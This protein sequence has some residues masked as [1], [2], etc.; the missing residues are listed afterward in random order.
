MVFFHILYSEPT[1]KL[2]IVNRVWFVKLYSWNGTQIEQD[3]VQ[4]LGIWL[5]SNLKTLTIKD[6]PSTSIIV[7]LAVGLSL[8]CM[9]SNALYCYQPL[10]CIDSEN[11]N[12]SWLTS[13]LMYFKSRIFFPFQVLSSTL[14][15]VTIVQLT[16]LCYKDELIWSDY[17]ETTLHCE[18]GGRFGV[19]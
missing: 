1:T 10:E 2:Y 18:V 19:N 8:Q 7:R 11:A 14:L 12:M 4:S 17:L 9:H 5:T 6:A 16:L 13:I 3:V 15:Y